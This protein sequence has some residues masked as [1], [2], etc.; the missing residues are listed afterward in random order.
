MILYHLQAMILRILSYF[1]DLFRLGAALD[2]AFRLIMRLV[3]M[4]L[5]P[6]FIVRTGIRALLRIRLISVRAQRSSLPC[7]T[8]SYC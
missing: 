6:D 1:W 8:S 3:E 4:D 5:V 2:A 7:T